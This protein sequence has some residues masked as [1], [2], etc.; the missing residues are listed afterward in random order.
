[1]SL[2]TKY[3]P[4]TFADVVEQNITTAILERQI[5]N[6]SF[7]NCYGF[8][9]TSG[10]G[11]TSLAR[12][13]ALAINNGVGDPIEIDGATAGSTENIKNIVESANT[14]SLTGEY[15][16]FIIDEC[17]MLGGGRKENSPAWAAFLKC[18]EDCPAY[19]IFIFCSTNPEKIPDAIMNRIQRYNFTPI[20]QKGIKNRLIYICQQEGFTNYE[21]TCDFISKICHGGM[22]DA[23][24]M[25]EQVADYSKDLDINIAKQIIGGLSYEVLFKL[26]WAIIQGQQAEIISMVDELYNNGQ[27]L[28][29]FVNTYL[30]FILDLIKYI[31]FKDPSLLTIPEYLASEGNNAVAATVDFKGSLKYFNTLSDKL[32]TLKTLIKT[33][34]SYKSTIEI[35]LIKTAIEMAMYYDRAE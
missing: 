3:R 26:T 17:Q 8:F 9:G 27:D 31:L 15:K 2:A 5:K 30:D 20:S 1:M 19:T 18:L 32:L 4:Q 33:D 28:R 11:K 10:T 23:I 34:N 6:R 14:R 25:L 29:L 7:K 16:I 35:F 22:R 21:M 12:V 24:A 13:F